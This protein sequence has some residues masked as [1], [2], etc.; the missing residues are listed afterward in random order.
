MITYKVWQPWVSET[1]QTLDC[2]I[3][4]VFK[5]VWGGGEVSTLHPKDRETALGAA[6][7]STPTL[8]VR[9]W[10]ATAGS[11]AD[12]HSNR[13]CVCLYKFL[14]TV[15]IIR[16]LSPLAWKGGPDP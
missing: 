12:H 1:E 15:K 9:G 7:S 11:P 3:R 4:V 14:T 6:L 2:D 13:P 8:Q 16:P 5:E 10:D